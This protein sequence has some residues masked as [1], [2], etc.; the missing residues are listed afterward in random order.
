MRETDALQKQIAAFETQIVEK[1]AATEEVD[2]EIESRADEINSHD[3]KRD[4]ALKAFDAEVAKSKSELEIEN[5][6][7]EEVFKTLPVQ[8]AGVYNRMAQQPRRHCRGRGGKRLVLGVLYVPA[9]ANA[10]RSKTR[11]PD[12]HVR[13]LHTN[14]LYRV[15]RTAGRSYRELENFHSDQPRRC[16]II[17]PC[18]AFSVRPFI[19]CHV[20]RKHL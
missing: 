12:H 1:M 14:S 2:T 19:S 7:R 18:R 3:A 15:A 17:E 11:R 13:K 5:A 20:S 16:G 9:A 4:E 8:L 10:P 6:K